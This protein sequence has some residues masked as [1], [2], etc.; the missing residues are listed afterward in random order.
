[1]SDTA[2]SQTGTRTSSGFGQTGAHDLYQRI[3]D[4]VIEMLDQGVVPWRSPILGRTGSR[5][6][7]NLNTGKQYRGINV[8]LLAFT[9]Y[10]KGYES[11]YWLT[12][13]QARDRGGNVKKGEKASMV[14]F[15]KQ[16]EVT[17][18]ETGEIKTVPILKFY[19]VFS[20]DQCEN[21]PAPDAPKFTPTPFNPIEA[22]EGIVK[23]YKD[24]PVIEHTGSQAY[25]KPSIDTVRIP[26]P[27]RFE[28]NEDYYSTILHEL[29]H[30]TGVKKRLNRGL[31]TDPR[32]FGSPDYGKEELVA[33]M[34][35]AFLC[36]HAGIHPA[37]IQNSAAYISGWLGLIK[38]DKKLVI[39][40]AGAAQK[41]AD[42]ILGTRAEKPDADQN[43]DG[44]PNRVAPQEQV[45]ACGTSPARIESVS[46]GNTD[47][48]AVLTQ[49]ARNYIHRGWAPV[50]IAAG[51]KAPCMKDWLNLR[52]TED[53]AAS[54]FTR[55][56][57]IGLI[58]GFPSHNLVDVDLDCPEARELADRFLP[59]T[60]GITG[61]P[62]SPAS[63]RWYI[64]PDV[65]TVRHRD[66][67]TRA[68]IVE[69]RGAGS[70]TLVGPSIHPSGEPYDPL[71]G[72]PA[73]VD[74]TRLW[75][76][77]DQ[78]AQEVIRL[79]HGDIQ[80]ANPPQ[81]PPEP[82]HVPISDDHNR[83]LTRAAAYL[84]ALPPAISG[85]GGH[86]ATFN[87]ATALVHGFGL[88]QSEALDL[89]ATRFNPRCSPAW[90]EKELQHKVADAAN[91]PH[92]RPFGWLRDSRKPASRA[93]GTLR[94]SPGAGPGSDGPTL[95]PQSP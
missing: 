24:G 32:P 39:L 80:P 72:Q 17:D 38:K 31:D 95:F 74:A 56:G 85:A 25:Y 91:R 27:T 26:E 43:D 64:A 92:T 9:A 65:Q 5:Q 75:E 23:G 45:A 2:D 52:L 16:Y 54:A 7:R 13:K 94:G 58:L 63:H 21:V 44:D 82:R 51:E 29:S 33:E 62:S 19:N 8:F 67:V 68:S 35:A 78:L 79:R 66:P 49:A 89:L 4:Q 6:P 76:S 55:A 42:W 87:A 81:Q 53:T 46:V 18:K 59:P 73:Q 61:R 93:A 22:A 83:L 47:R 14:V 15:W 37:V 34:S 57:N 20:V 11:A 77:V 84:D 40:A 50:P 41:S 60:A 28:K 30:S 88:S 69:L 48:A 86:N 90:T 10:A 3:T 12:F 36:G 71:D 1:M 70:Q